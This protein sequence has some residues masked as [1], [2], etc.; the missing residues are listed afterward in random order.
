M[1]LYGLQGSL[2]TY[3]KVVV[4]CCCNWMRLLETLGLFGTSPHDVQIHCS[5]PHLFGVLHFAE[6][7]VTA[8]LSDLLCDMEVLI[9]RYLQRR[10]R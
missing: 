9:R 1:D 10:K 5:F 7:C 3:H 4:C 6:V 8:S 2:D